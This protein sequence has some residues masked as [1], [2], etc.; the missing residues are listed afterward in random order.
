[1]FTSSIANSAPGQYVIA[2]LSYTE[3]V[4]TKPPSA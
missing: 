3:A 4:K 1:M 2:I